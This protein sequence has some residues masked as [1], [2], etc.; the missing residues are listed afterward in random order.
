MDIVITDPRDIRQTWM[1][2]GYDLQAAIE[3]NPQNDF[4]FLDI[5]RVIA[6]WEGENDGDS[7]RWIVA[8]KSGRFAYLIGG[9][10]YTGWDCQSWLS[11]VVAD[12]AEAATSIGFEIDNDPPPVR[13]SISR[14]IQD[15]VDQTWRD[16]MDKQFEFLEKK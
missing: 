6:V 9:C 13:K 7:W 3:Y 8:L 5:V 1:V 4:N 2:G 12:N 15:G 14:Q 10:D 16:R 11:S